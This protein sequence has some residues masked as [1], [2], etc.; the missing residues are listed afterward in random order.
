MGSYPGSS[1]ETPHQNRKRPLVGGFVLFKRLFV[2]VTVTRM[3]SYC[4]GHEGA[5]CG[6][7]ADQLPRWCVQVQRGEAGQA[8][9]GGLVVPKPQVAGP[10]PRSGLQQVSLLAHR[11]NDLVP[12]GNGGTGV[13]E[14]AAGGVVGAPDAQAYRRIGERRRVRQV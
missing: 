13:A 14:V 12:W 4:H 7:Q 8:S 1:Y 5:S 2:T 11:G 6:A 10:P 3:D 9:A